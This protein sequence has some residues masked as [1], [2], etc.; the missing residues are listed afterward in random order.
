VGVPKGQRPLAGPRPRL[1]D[2]IKT[3]FTQEG[4]KLDL[5]GEGKGQMAGSCEHSNEISGSI[6]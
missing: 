6:Q 4:N 2:N 3:D 5:C 1:E